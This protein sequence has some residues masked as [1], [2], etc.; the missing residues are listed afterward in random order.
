[1]VNLKISTGDFY[2]RG[3]Y[4]VQNGFQITQ[5]M[6]GQKMNGME[7]FVW[8]EEK[9]L[10]QDSG[11]VVEFPDC[12]RRGNLY[13]V[14][15]TLTDPGKVY[16]YRLLE[17]SR[18]L[19]DP[20]AT[21][22]V[23]VEKKTKATAG[24]PLTDTYGILRKTSYNWG[25]DKLPRLDLS[26]CILYGLHVKGFTRDESAHVKHPGTFRGVIEKLPYLKKLGITS[27][28]LQPVYDFAPLLMRPLSGELT[29][30][31]WGYTEGNY[32]AP[33]RRYASGPDAAGE[34]KDLVK[35]FHKQNMEVIMQLGF[36]RGVKADYLSDILFYWKETFHM[37]G[38]SFIGS[39]I[40]VEEI[41]EKDFL[42][43]TKL[44]AQD[45]G[46]IVLTHRE[47]TQNNP[48]LAEYRLDFMNVCRRFLKGDEDTVAAFTYQN[49][50]VPEGYHTI[51]YMA[52]FN[53]F[54]M[55]DLVSYERKHNE[56][57]G[58]DNKDGENFNNSWNCGAE[59]ETKKAAV[60]K[61]R[62]KQLKNAACLLFLSQGTPYIF[63]GDEFGD[64][65]R[66]NNNPYN[67]DNAITY[68]D[69]NARLRNRAYAAFFRE[70]IALKKQSSILQKTKPLRPNDQLG[71][72]IPEISYHGEALWRPNMDSYIRHIGILLSEKETFYIAF[73]MH[74]EEHTFSLPPLS[75]KK[76]WKLLFTTDGSVPAV[77]EQKREI[78]EEMTGKKSK[79]PALGYE[80][81][82]LPRTVAV[83][84]IQ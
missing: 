75:G 74:W 77:T 42:S 46:D 27:V 14:R 55:M 1:M 5:T 51:H 61:L 64:T 12:C 9:G 78:P 33:N 11:K 36:P 82:I 58:E 32:F 18:P 72:G 3:T 83:F 81:I 16:A 69:W 26:S 54:R 53:T 8:D 59:G 21:E 67:Q 13:A 6:H 25:N 24:F 15:I 79:R 31:Y 2:H 84:G 30:N 34:L 63:M 56:E 62:L 73:N 23:R 43:D 70:L 4:Q 38:F 37:D 65:A 29:T 44:I 76:T 45:L 7:I 60:R 68:V 22:V 49:R 17:D 52:D 66:G 48:Y 41:L 47:K 20:Y 57:N 80:T 40:P 39:Q 10:L 71:E 50:F 19:M 35:A 28:V